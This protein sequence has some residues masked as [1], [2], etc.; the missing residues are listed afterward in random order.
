VKV[1]HLPSADSGSKSMIK[2]DSRSGSK[3]TSQTLMVKGLE[4]H[5]SVIRWDFSLELDTYMCDCVEWKEH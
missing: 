3:P 2:M 1:K 4:C 5:A